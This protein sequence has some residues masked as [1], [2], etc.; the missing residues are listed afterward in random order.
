MAT[1]LFQ[2]SRCQLLERLRGWIDEVPADLTTKEKER[3][4]ESLQKALGAAKSYLNHAEY[5]TDA[6]DISGT[7]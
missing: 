6:T 4:R 2:T 3:R 5:W 1:F 7:V